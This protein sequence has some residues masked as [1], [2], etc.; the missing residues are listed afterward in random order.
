MV[1]LISVVFVRHNLYYYEANLS[2]V[3]DNLYHRLRYTTGRFIE[4]TD[5]IDNSTLT[6]TSL[7]NKGYALTTLMCKLKSVKTLK[8]VF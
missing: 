6:T 4:P 8:S 7:T 5:K 1:P 2:N 3:P